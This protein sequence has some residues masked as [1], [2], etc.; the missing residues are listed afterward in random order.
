[1]ICENNEQQICLNNKSDPC[2]TFRYFHHEKKH[3]NINR[4]LAKEREE[5]LEKLKVL[6]FSL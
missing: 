5:T 4:H 2:E 1:M 6:S 3:E